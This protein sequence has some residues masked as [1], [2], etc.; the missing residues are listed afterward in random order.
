M[1]FSIKIQI[2]SQ[3]KKKKK[4]QIWFLEMKKK[5]FYNKIQIYFLE[6][7]RRDFI[8]KFRYVFFF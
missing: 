1:T 2:F 4:I 6:M 7:K 8:I 5:R 3:P